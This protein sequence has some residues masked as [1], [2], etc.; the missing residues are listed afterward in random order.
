MA[1]QTERTVE[2]IKA[3][4]LTSVK[5]GEFIADLDRHRW[6]LA[7]GQFPVLAQ[8]TADLQNKG[9][10]DFLAFATDEV[11]DGVE[12]QAFF[13]LHLFFCEFVPLIAAPAHVVVPVVE[14]L[15][16]KAGND[17]IAGQ[18]YNAFR[19]WCENGP[20][21]PHET[22]EYYGRTAGVGATIPSIALQVGARTQFKKYYEEA[23]Q[24]VGSDSPDKRLAG[25][26]ALGRL[27]FA[28]H[29][30]LR[31]EA[32]NRPNLLPRMERRSP[33]G[34]ATRWRPS[35]GTSPGKI[36]LPFPKIPGAT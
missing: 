11:L 6:S 1:Q 4:V 30:D 33:C 32:F 2:E 26:G 7:D 10:I 34:I 20:E 12:G 8:A 21:R 25:A 31:S 28:G 18:A 36:T 35:R 16:R 19:A 5:Q 9:E 13:D 3:E 15:F 22:L 17:G 14:R 29:D 27:D 24:F 23:V